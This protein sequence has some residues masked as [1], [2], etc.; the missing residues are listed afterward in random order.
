MKPTKAVITQIGKYTTDISLD[1]LTDLNNE[2]IEMLAKELQKQID[3]EV[4]RKL[5]VSSGWYEAV[6]PKHHDVTDEW[7]KQYIKGDYRC[8]GHYWYFT[9]EKDF[10]FFVLRWSA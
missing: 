2:I 5:L 4:A 6:I 10:E 1:S 7:C 3:E 9:L 8:F